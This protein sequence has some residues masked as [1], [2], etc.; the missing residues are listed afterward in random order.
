MRTIESALYNFQLMFLQLNNPVRSNI[1]IANVKYDILHR[2]FPSWF[3][4]LCK[5]LK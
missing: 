4:R 5:E 3:S 2:A 1:P